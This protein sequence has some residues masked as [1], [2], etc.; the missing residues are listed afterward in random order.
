MELFIKDQKSVGG[1][2]IIDNSNNNNIIKYDTL[3][4]DV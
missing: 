1:T 3:F 4:D 2:I